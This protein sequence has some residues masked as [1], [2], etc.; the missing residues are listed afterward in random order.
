MNKN[1]ADR[2]KNAVDQ[3]VDIEA[4]AG[5]FQKI[6]NYISKKVMKWGALGMLGMTIFGVGRQA[7][8]GLKS[9]D[10]SP[11]TEQ[12]FSGTVHADSLMELQTSIVMAL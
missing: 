11:Q 8:E 10:N 5:R 3:D 7:S 12:T 9:N 2:A 4:K 6:R 1:R